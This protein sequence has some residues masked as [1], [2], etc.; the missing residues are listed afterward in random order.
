MAYELFCKWQCEYSKG[1]CKVD[2]IAKGYEAMSDNCGFVQSVRE[3]LKSAGKMHI[4]RD[5]SVI[6]GLK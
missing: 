4:I 1:Y 5:G 3:L 2:C 6:E